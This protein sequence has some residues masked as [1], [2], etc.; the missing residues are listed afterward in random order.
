M[1]KY[2]TD[3]TE[4]LS[5]DVRSL[6]LFRILLGIY[7]L[8][9]TI[10]RIKLTPAFYSDSGILP[11]YMVDL[12]N[13]ENMYHFKL[14]MISG[15]GWFAYLFFGIAIAVSFFLI[16]GFKTRFITFM[17]WLMYVS[18]VIRDPLTKHAGDNLYILMLFWGMFL[19]LGRSFSVDALRNNHTSQKNK[20]IL[21]AAGIGLYVQFCLVYIMTGLYK[22]QYSSWFNGTHLYNTY[23]RFDYVEPLAFWI[24]PQYEL[25]SFLTHFTLWLELLGSLLFFIPVFFVYFRMLGIFLF[26]GLQLVIGLTMDVGLFPLV[27]IAGILVFIPACVW[28]ELSARLKKVGL[29]QRYFRAA[30]HSLKKAVPSNRDKALTINRMPLFGEVLISLLIGYVVVWNISDFSFRFSL[31]DTMKKPGYALKLDQRWTMFAAPALNAHYFSAELTYD[32]GSTKNI[33]AH[34][35]KKHT[36]PAPFHHVGYVNYRW[37]IFFSNRLSRLQYA[38]YRP[39]VLNY[40]LRTDERK[41]DTTEIIKSPNTLQLVAHQHEIGERYLHSEI[42]PVILYILYFDESMPNYTIE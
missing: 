8:L 24:Y 18:F 10:N 4:I 17:A 13:F 32:D 21:S 11:R 30:K 25:L 36:P 7:L 3:V 14:M 35:T 27:S 41:A 19:P 12:G 26:A 39:Y 33:M 1:K 42:E 6:A 28:G 31:S 9:D 37:R 40:L 23:S 38:E 20:Y 2:I 29:W 22:A 5:L 34:L 15:E 16:F